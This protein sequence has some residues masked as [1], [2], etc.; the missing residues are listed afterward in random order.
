[1]NQAAK[2]LMDRLSIHLENYG[3]RA[4]KGFDG[5]NFKKREKFG[6][7]ELTIT[8]FNVQLE[9]EYTVFRPLVCVRHDR[10]DNIVNQLGHIWGTANR[11]RTTTVCRSLELFPFVAERDRPQTI[12]NAHRDADT[13][14]ATENIL[15]ML[16]QD[17]FAFF[18]RYS[19]IDECASGLNQ[20][21][22]TLTHPLL[23]NLPLR[24][25]Y[26]V[27]AAALTRPHSVA[28]LM[29]EY[30]EY[31]RVSGVIDPL[32]YEFGKSNGGIDGI[33][34]RLKKI[35]ELAVEAS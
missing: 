24:A 10:L 7:F 26:G 3:F 32:Q 29:K 30:L 1:M 25:Y 15:M 8:F 11:K 19:C 35:V 22:C 6:F 21:I 34:Q 12:R 23:N 33:E 16:Q 9:E 2:S 31:I 17:G 18:D 13:A 27:A 4:K 20:P 28:G 14:L 5:I